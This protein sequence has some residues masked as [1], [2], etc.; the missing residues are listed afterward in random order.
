MA[1]NRSS[2]RNIII[3]H[4]L[5]EFPKQNIRSKLATYNGNVG[6]EVHPIHTQHAATSFLTI[7]NELQIPKQKLWNPNSWRLM[8]SKHG[9]G[10]RRPGGSAI[11]YTSKLASLDKLFNNSPRSK[12]NAN[13]KS[14]PQLSDSIKNNQKIQ[15]R[16]LQ[17]NKDVRN[18]LG[19]F[20]NE[21]A[22]RKQSVN[23][24]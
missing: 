8:A 9:K 20:A 3:N 6:R 5:I 18:K 21:I 23:L 10:R 4:S 16:I 19:I 7:L 11:Y 1:V 12:Q 15:K 13:P 2:L 14:N 24:L 17:K 22:L